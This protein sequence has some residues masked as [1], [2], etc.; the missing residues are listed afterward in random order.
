M[1]PVNEPLLDGHELQYVSDCVTSGWI[2]SAGKYISDFERQWA[3][4]CGMKHG[5][6]VC[7]GTIALELAIEILDFPEGS[8]IILPDFTI[9]SCAQAIT[10]AGCVPVVV[11]CDPDTWCMDVSRIE[12]V[13]TPKTRAV[14][15]VHIYGHAVDMDPLMSLA[16]KYGLKVIEDAAEVH[17]AEYKGKKC[18]GFGDV[19]CFSF[20]ANK[21]ITTGEGG[22][23]LTNSDELAEK[24][25]SYRNL[26]FQSKQRFLHEEIGHNFRFTN[27]QAALGLAQ[28]ERIEKFVERKREMAQMYNEGLA[29]LPLQLPVEKPWA[30]NVYWMYGLVIDEKTGITAKD[31]AVRLNEKG[32]ETRPFFLGMHEQPVFRKAGLFQGISLPTTER[33]SRY[34]L[35]L[36]SGQAITDDQINNVIVA[37]KSIFQ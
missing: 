15:P 3:D 37:L 14:M 32:I 33:I 25:K 24:L 19:S 7:N 11:D 26:C 2:S 22:M 21:I 23:I 35:Y 18:G 12:A 16:E 30:K 6:S 31:L 10:K 36:P 17:G 5:I 1:I 27:I 4:Y 8:E 9:I 34:G 28:L 20:F 13:I 29:S